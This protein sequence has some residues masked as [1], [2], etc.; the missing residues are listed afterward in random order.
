MG[1]PGMVKPG[2]KNMM[3]FIVAVTFI[4]TKSFPAVSLHESIWLSSGLGRFDQHLPASGLFCLLCDKQ[5][6]NPLSDLVLQAARG[7]QVF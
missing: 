4:A 3:R 7:S 5:P 1:N 2:A 6:F